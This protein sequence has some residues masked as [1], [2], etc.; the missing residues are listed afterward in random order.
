MNEQPVIFL[1]HGAGPSFFLDGERHKWCKGL[2]KHS[3]AAQFFK[4]FTENVNLNKPTAILVFSA[5]WE[6]TLCTIQTNSKPELYYDYGGFPPETYNLAW[7]ARG[8]PDIAKQA[9][10]LLESNGIQCVENS[11][12]GFDHGVFVPLKQMFPKADIPGMAI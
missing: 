7:G 4:D 12:R 11:K 8:A 1:T 5:H 9:R 3:K 10:N 6:E 2:D